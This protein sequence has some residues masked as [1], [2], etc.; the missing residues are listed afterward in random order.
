MKHDGEER[1]PAAWMLDRSGGTFI[2]I[3]IAAIVLV[4]ANA[5]L[6][7]RIGSWFMGLFS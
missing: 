4:I 2:G 1:N 3:L 5:Y 7:V 6:V